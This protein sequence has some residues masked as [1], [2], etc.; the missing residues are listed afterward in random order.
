MPVARAAV[1]SKLPPVLDI[2]L[3]DLN[4][5]VPETPVQIVCSFITHCQIEIANGSFQPFVPDFWE[6][7]K[8]AVT[9]AQEA[10]PSTP[11]LILTA[12][13][14]THHGGGPSLNAYDFTAEST[15]SSSSRSDG[16][17]GIVSDVLDDL[18]LA[19]L[20]LSPKR[21]AKLEAEMKELLTYEATVPENREYSRKLDDGEKKGLY[22]LLGIFG[23]GWLLGGVFGH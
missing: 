16:S 20:Q 21:D 11:K 14:S 6:S 17:G 18:G 4:Q 23:G 3:P 22:V 13:S 9:T 10:A 12:G 15:E 7:S 8:E 19:G 1:L 5:P 2:H